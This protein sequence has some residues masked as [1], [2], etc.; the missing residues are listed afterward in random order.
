VD[1]IRRRHFTLKTNWQLRT[2]DNRSS[3]LTAIRM[4][5]SILLNKQSDLSGGMP[6]TISTST[7]RVH[8]IL[9]TRTA[10]FYAPLAHW[11][12]SLV[13]P[14]DGQISYFAP[15][16]FVHTF[17]LPT[18]D[19]KYAS[20]GD[21][22]ISL[23]LLSSLRAPITLRKRLLDLLQCHTYSNTASYSN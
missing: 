4:R 16:V 11:F 18:S 15:P 20:Q 7:K 9:T 2:W 21:H 22:P 13:R 17:N 12:S 3:Q 23:W 19:R 5:T 8:S 14:N 6:M 10:S 1:S